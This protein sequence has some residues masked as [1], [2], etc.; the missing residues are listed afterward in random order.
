P[1][2]H[3]VESFRISI[4]ES[5]LRIF[6]LN[7]TYVY[8][9][10]FAS[11]ID[12]SLLLARE[13]KLTASNDLEFADVNAPLLR[14]MLLFDKER[15]FKMTWNCD[16]DNFFGCNEIPGLFGVNDAKGIRFYQRGGQVSGT[17]GLNLVDRI[18]NSSSYDFKENS[19]TL[20]NGAI[21]YE[22]TEQ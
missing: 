8:K 5:E 13:W 16:Q 12:E 19:L 2:D 14:P 15:T 21:F 6:A 4:S 18:L 7:S 17:R 9:S 3:L 22:F 20:R 1:V 10:D 11:S